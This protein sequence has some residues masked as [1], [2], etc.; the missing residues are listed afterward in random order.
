MIASFADFCL[1]VYVLVDD[2]LA[3][4]ALPARRG[5]APCCSDSEL[6][7][8]ALVGE[9]RGWDRETEL[10]AA[11]R[12]YPDLFPRLPERSRFNRRR[13]QLMGT[14]NA[15]RQQIL[16]RFDGA[17]DSHWGIDSLPVPVM[18]F[19][20]VPRSAAKADWQAAGAR[21]GRIESKH[22][23]IFGYKLHLLVSF[24]G[25]IGDFS[26]ASANIDD[27]HAGHELLAAHGQLLVL[28]DKGYRSA[29]VAA[30]LRARQLIHLLTIPRK[31]EAVPFEPAL[32]K[33]HNHFRH[34]IETVG[35]QL[36]EQ[37]HI[38]RNHAKTFWG[39]CTRLYSKLTAHTVC[40]YLNWLDG[41]PN[42]LQIKHL[43]FPN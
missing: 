12:A 43:A 29:P 16:Q 41:S 3:T 22:Q 9:C 14:I 4:L 30:A 19:H 35:S 11:F 27:L 10:L 8:L 17:A 20:L 37:L 31:N 24:N 28:G 33:L 7:T 25:V 26:L 1:H 34:I 2:L 32:V 18:A 13:R 38:E 21:Y 6:I 36:S 39:L 23:T 42:W 15:L 40:L 5:P